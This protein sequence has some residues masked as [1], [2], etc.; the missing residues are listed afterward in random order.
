MQKLNLINPIRRKY[1][2]KSIAPK[3]EEA[4][5]SVS[6]PPSAVEQNNEVKPADQSP[7]KPKPSMP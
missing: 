4:P 6:A 1:P 2:L 7:L 3:P 5:A